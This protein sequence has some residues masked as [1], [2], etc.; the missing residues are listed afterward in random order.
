MPVG[1]ATSKTHCWPPQSKPR[2]SSLHPTRDPLLLFQN[3]ASAVLTFLIHSCTQEP[4]LITVSQ[5]C[6]RPVQLEGSCS[7]SSAVLSRGCIPAT[8][9]DQCRCSSKA[10]RRARNS[11]L[12]PIVL[13]STIC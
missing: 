9:R 6:P 5:L 13:N 3:S 12:G 7:T 2:S 4:V 10:Q 1:M 11:F 8:I